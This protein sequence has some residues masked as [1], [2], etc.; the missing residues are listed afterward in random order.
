MSVHDVQNNF[1][2]IIFNLFLKIYLHLVIPVER[3]ARYLV[4]LRVEAKYQ[5]VQSA[6]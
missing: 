5:S 3:L 6:V 4:D 1:V 2:Y